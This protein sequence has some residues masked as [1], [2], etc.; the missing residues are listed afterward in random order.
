MSDRVFGVRVLVGVRSR[1]ARC[2]SVCVQSV[3]LHGPGTR[4]HRAGTP[5]CCVVSS[6]LRSTGA[7]FCIVQNAS[8]VT[9]PTLATVALRKHPRHQV[10]VAQVSLCATCRSVVGVRVLL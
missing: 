9:G 3:R 5:G 2:G 8:R 1:S 7:S 10:R 4:P 6:R